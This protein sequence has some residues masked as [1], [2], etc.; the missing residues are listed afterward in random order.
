MH[1]S[2]AGHRGV[3]FRRVL[4][5]SLLVTTIE[6]CADRRVAAIQ[7][8]GGNVGASDVQVSTDKSRYAHGETVVVTV[9]N[10]RGD[11][12]YALTGKTYCSILSVERRV[13]GVWTAEGPCMVLGPPGWIEIKPQQAMR[14]ELKPRLP[15]DLPLAPDRHRVVFAFR[16]KTTT[17]P[18]ETRLSSEFD[19]SP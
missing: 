13:N 12:L 17:A 5:L 4:T 11:S 1:F 15:D 2:N 6:C 10:A 16:A 3:R 14:V 19:V 18:T 8:Q 7:D 9:M